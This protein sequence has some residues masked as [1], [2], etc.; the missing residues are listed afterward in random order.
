MRT[1]EVRDVIGFA[2]LEDCYGPC[3]EKR[4]EEGGLV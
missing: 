1:S 3:G 2:L 4:H